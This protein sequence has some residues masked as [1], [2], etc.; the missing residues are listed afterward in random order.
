MDTPLSKAEYVRR[1]LRQEIIDGKLPPGAKLKQVAIAERLGV[2]PTPV[3]E[4]LRLLQ[5][6]HMVVLT[7]SQGVIVTDFDDEA[8]VGFYLIRA[9][10]EG[11]CARMAAE[12]AT[13]EIIEGLTH[14]HESLVLMDPSSDP[15]QLRE[16]NARFHGAIRDAC[17]N[18]VVASEAARLWEAVPRAPDHRSMWAF[19]E[20]RRTLVRDHQ[21][22]LDAIRAGDQDEADQA[23]GEHL[24]RTLHMFR[25]QRALAKTSSRSLDGA[26]DV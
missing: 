4:A 18:W 1:V 15:E 8:L 2:S 5:S 10:I 21:R 23:M 14:A 7:P 19:S 3:R 13:P 26:T 9:R 11:L 20:H 12:R 22:I 25:T 17:G 24:M 6:E 16:M